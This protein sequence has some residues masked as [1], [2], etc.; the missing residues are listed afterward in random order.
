MS[1]GYVLPG[2]DTDCSVVG[3]VLSK[4]IHQSEAILSPCGPN[5]HSGTPN[6]AYQTARQPRPR[7][8]CRRHSHPRHGFGV[9]VVGGNDP[10]RTRLHDGEPRHYLYD[11]TAN[12]GPER[13]VRH[14]G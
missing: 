14:C 5:D 3:S 2:A 1:L 11:Q 12:D 4:G 6:A 13:D 9:T 7:E 10:I 8:R